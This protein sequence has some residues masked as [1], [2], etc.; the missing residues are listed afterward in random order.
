MRINLLSYSSSKELTVGWLTM[1]VIGTDLFVV[2]PLLPLI[3]ADY[4]ISPTLAALSVTSFALSYM[5]SAPILGHLADKTGRG[6][7]LMWCLCGF[8]AANLLTALAG[9]LTWLIAARS[10]AG[11]AASGVSPVIYTLIGGTA[12]PDRRATWLSIAVSGLLMSLSFGASTGTLLGAALGWRLVFGGV[13]ALS[14]MLV[15]ANKRVWR[16]A[17]AVANPAV[18]SRQLRLSAVIPRLAPTVVWSTAVY[19]T[20]T[21]LGE[22]LTSF[23]YSTEVIAGVIGLYGWGAICGVLLGG[24]MTDRL[25]ARL[26]STIGLS[27]LCCGFFLLRL[28]LDAGLLVGCAF[29]LLSLLAQLFFPAQQMGLAQGFPAARSTILAWNN[30]ALF[31]GIALGSVI[32]GQATHLAG[33]SLNLAISAFIAAI[34]LAFNEAV[35]PSRP[36]T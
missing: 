8:A 18:T 16:D 31:L 9:N 6:Q 10:C 2:S 33:F 3:A 15:W 29:G 19:V 25:G 30:S 7:V 23:G 24:R 35:N 13:A 36:P 21:Y 14:V 20:Y 17:C 34:A 32:G 4:G 11:A 26:T 22:G 12:P 27:S 1:F 28:L 5:L